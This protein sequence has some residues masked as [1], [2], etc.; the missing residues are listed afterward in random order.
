MPVSRTRRV[1]RHRLAAEPDELHEHDVQDAE[2]HQR[3]HQLPRVAEDGA[4]ELQL[5]VRHRE[6]ARELEEAPCGRRRARSGR[7]FAAARGPLTAGVLTGGMLP[8]DRRRTPADYRYGHVAGRRPDSGRRGCLEVV[9]PSARTDSHPQGARGA[10]VPAPRVRAL[11]GASRCLVLGRAGRVLRDRRPERIRQEHAAEV[12]GG[13]LR[14]RS[15]ARSR[16]AGACR[17]SSSSAWAST[18][19]SRRATTS[20]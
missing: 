11:G 14:D 12:H 10:S 16:S 2:E 15:G 18:P 7:G 8:A 6:R 19:T 20:S 4:E 5:E 3:P 1:V 9:P 17:R 13:H